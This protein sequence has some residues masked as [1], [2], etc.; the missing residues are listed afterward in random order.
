MKNSQY[1]G[2]A[3]E[4]FQPGLKSWIVLIN[5]TW[6]ILENEVMRRVDI[7]DGER[8]PSRI[9]P[10]IGLAREYDEH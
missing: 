5:R 3:F 10:C 2:A 7:F 9:P 4:R 8:R 1:E 6:M